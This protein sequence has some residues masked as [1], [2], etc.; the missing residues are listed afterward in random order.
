MSAIRRG[1]GYEVQFA[2]DVHLGRLARDLRMLGFDTAWTREVTDPEL[3]EQMRGEGRQLLSRDRRLVEEAQAG[4]TPAL[5]PHYVRAT[6][7][8][9]Q[10]REVLSEFELLDTARSM[11]GFLTRCLECNAPILRIQKRLA[12][13]RVPREVVERHE[14]FFLCPRCERVYWRGSHFDRM[15]E[16]VTRVLA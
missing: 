11:Q 6:E 16:W 1:R 10:L 15:R 4:A 12:L 7:P 3:L 13:E 2:L 9:A 14:E 8:E 5:R